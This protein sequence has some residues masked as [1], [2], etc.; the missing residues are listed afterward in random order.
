LSINDLLEKFQNES[1]DVT[2]QVKNEDEATDTR[3]LQ[4]QLSEIHFD[5]KKCQILVLHDITQ[6]GQNLRLK[7]QVEA[8]NLTSSYMSHEMVTPL[9]CVSQL[10]DKVKKSEII[11]P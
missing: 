1:L 11:E 6:V 7:E 5:S 8:A 9:K 4:L 3:Y 2:Y 10:V